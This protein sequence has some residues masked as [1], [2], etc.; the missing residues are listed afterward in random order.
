M[1][2]QFFPLNLEQQ[3]RISSGGIKGFTKYKLGSCSFLDKSKK[4]FTAGYYSI[5]NFG[6]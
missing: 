2:N 6:Y 4:E 5:N 3:Q 1:G